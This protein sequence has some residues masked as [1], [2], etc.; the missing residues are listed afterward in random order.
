MV[1]FLKVKSQAV[2]KI[3]D[4]ITYLSVREKTLCTI[5]MDRGTKFINNELKTWCHLQG[6]RLQM[7]APYHYERN[8]Y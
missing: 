7:T 6:I 3:K 4:Q 1:N 2:Q 8:S 5:Q